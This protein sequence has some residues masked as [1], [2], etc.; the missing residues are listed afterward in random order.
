MFEILDKIDKFLEQYLP[1]LTKEEMEQLDRLPSIK[2]ITFVIKNH[3]T[4][5]IPITDGSTC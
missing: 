4:K 1:Q 2:E 3:S 5:K